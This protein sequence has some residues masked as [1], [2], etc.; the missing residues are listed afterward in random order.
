MQTAERFVT[1]AERF[2]GQKQSA[3]QQVR[4]TERPKLG[5]LTV[6]AKVEAEHLAQDVERL[7]RKKQNAERILKTLSAQMLG[8]SLSQ[9]KCRLSGLAETLSVW[10]RI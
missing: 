5:K 4:T 2:G 6:S 3:E 7:G 8:S 10:R 9:Q 1:T